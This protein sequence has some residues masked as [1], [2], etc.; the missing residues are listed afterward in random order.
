MHAFKR[1]LRADARAALQ[2]IASLPPRRAVEALVAMLEG[3]LALYFWLDQRAKIQIGCE[4]TNFVFLI[5]KKRD[6]ITESFIFWRFLRLVENLIRDGLVVLRAEHP[7]G[8]LGEEDFSPDAV[9]SGLGLKNEED[10]LEMEKISGH[11]PRRP[12]VRYKAAERALI[13]A[14]RDKRAVSGQNWKCPDKL[15]Q[16]ELFQLAA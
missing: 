15:Q 11:K 2:I 5:K 8:L 13:L 14:L 9:L 16:G 6:E 3:T 10:L 1:A 4:I 12:G 7:V